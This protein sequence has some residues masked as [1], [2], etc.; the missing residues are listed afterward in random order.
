MGKKKKSRSKNEIDSISRTVK[1]L[2]IS[3]RSEN[4]WSISVRTRTQ[5][6]VPMHR[7]TILTRLKVFQ[8]Q[9]T[10]RKQCTVKRDEYELRVLTITIKKKI[11]ILIFGLFG[12]MY[13]DGCYSGEYLFEASRNRY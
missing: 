11:Y 13:V 6:V 9:F 3:K 10:N 7:N 12:D 8:Y 5:R 4:L 2:K 1:N